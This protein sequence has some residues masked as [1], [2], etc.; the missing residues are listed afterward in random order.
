MSEEM[1]I[2]YCAP[3]LAGLKTGSMFVCDYKD[4][5]DLLDEIR[6]YNRMLVPKGLRLIPMRIQ[7][8]KAIIYVYR[9]SSLESDL[10]DKRAFKVLKEKGY[11]CDRQSEC[12]SCL[13]KHINAQSEF[14]HEVGLFLGYPPEDVIGFIDNNAR[15]YKYCGP[16]KV[17]GNISKAKKTFAIFKKCT[18]NFENRHKN[19]V[20]IRELTVAG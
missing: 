15:N 6:A 17:Y 3:T 20:P 9:V 7:N 8:D 10:K 16:W 14:P 2:K 4:K 12:V 11:P 13:K 18:G 19:G 1:I 5:Y